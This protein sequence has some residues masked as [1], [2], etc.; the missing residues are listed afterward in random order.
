[1]HGNLKEL[2]GFV[3]TPDLLVKEMIKMLPTEVFSNDKLKW[4]D[5]GCGNGAIS[6]EIL[7]VLMENLNKSRD[8][9]CEKNIYMVESNP[10]LIPNL[11]DIFS[12]KANI[13]DIDF[14]LYSPEIKFDVIVSN[15][16]YNL[17]GLKTIPKKKRDNKKWIPIWHSFLEKSLELLN[18]NG[19][20]CVIVPA[21]WLKYDELNMYNTITQYKIHK[22]KCYNSYE[23]YKIFSKK[24]QIPCTLFLLQKKPTDFVIP[25]MDNITHEY[26]I[27]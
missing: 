14:L 6:K 1:M 12:L 7:K 4:L 23:S 21:S 24:V 8:D 22:M 9:I 3:E 5:P 2:F 20:M 26:V 27:T 18:D 17:N 19:Y 10:L 11:K 13:D 25:I 16:P 15:P